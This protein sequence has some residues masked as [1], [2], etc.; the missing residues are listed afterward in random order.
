MKCSGAQGPFRSIQA[1]RM[2]WLCTTQTSMV[3]GMTKVGGIEGVQGHSCAA[4]R[5]HAM[6][7]I[8]PEF[9]MGQPAPLIPLL[10]LPV[11][12]WTYFAISWESILFYNK[13]SFKHGGSSLSGGPHSPQS[14]D[15]RRGG[16][17]GLDSLST[18]L[19]VEHLPLPCLLRGA[20]N[21]LSWQRF[22]NW[23][24]IPPL[25]HF[26]CPTGYIGEKTTL[27]SRTIHTG[28]EAHG[29]GC[30]DEPPT[31]RL[32]ALWCPQL[33]KL[34]YRNTVK[35]E[36]CNR[37]NRLGRGKPAAGFRNPRHSL[38]ELWCF[39]V[40]G[41]KVSKSFTRKISTNIWQKSW[42][43][44]P[45]SSSLK[46]R[47]HSYTLSKHSKISHLLSHVRTSLKILKK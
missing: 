32:K 17:V 16:M 18:S 22:L 30:K 23:L 37:E 46:A 26:I 19:P 45:K 8:E 10:S 41:W 1:S 9:T 40:K 20:G 33:E 36:E 21:S 31:F 27:C 3:L 42:A 13:F 15:S 4:Q 2:R 5:D 28:G 47:C 7:E 35:Q 38:E 12:I 29:L 44:D 34:F 6:L 39:S 14:I 25:F 24:L 11:L 43:N